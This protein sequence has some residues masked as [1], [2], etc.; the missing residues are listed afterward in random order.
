MEL[1]DINYW[2]GLIQFGLTALAALCLIVVIKLLKRTKK[3]R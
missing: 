2:P 1:L 3:K